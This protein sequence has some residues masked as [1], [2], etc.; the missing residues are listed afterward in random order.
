MWIHYWIGI[1]NL[2][3]HFV[4]IFKRLLFVQ[5]IYFSK[6]NAIS[7]YYVHVCSYPVSFMSVVQLFPML[8]I[9]NRMMQPQS[10]GI[11]SKIYQ[12]FLQSSVITRSPN[13]VST[14]PQGTPLHHSIK[15]CMFDLDDQPEK[16]CMWYI[17]ACR[18][19]AFIIDYHNCF[20]FMQ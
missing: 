20:L 14:M 18:M 8:Q 19:R 1:K 2:V 5:Y 10:R 13:W 6:I 12:C 15:N 9:S 17:H 4:P 3:L 11:T 16:C 7:L